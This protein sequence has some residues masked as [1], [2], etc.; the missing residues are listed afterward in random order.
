MRPGVLVVVL[1]VVLLVVGL[2]EERE[3]WHLE[4]WHLHLWHLRGLW[5]LDLKWVVVLVGVVVVGVVV[6]RNQ[7][8][9][10][11]LLSSFQIL[12]ELLN[13]SL[14]TLEEFVHIWEHELKWINVLVLVVHVEFLDLGVEGLLL[15]VGSLNGLVPLVVKATEGGGELT[16]IIGESVKL[17][18]LLDVRVAGVINV[19]ELADV[20][21][22]AHDLEDVI[23]DSA[24]HVLHEDALSWVGDAPV[25][26]VVL[27][28]LEVADLG[29]L[30]ED[31]DQLRSDFLDLVDVDRPEVLMGF[32]VELLGLVDWSLNPGTEALIGDNFVVLVV[33]TGDEA[34]VSVLHE[35][36][37]HLNF[38][39][40]WSTSLWAVG[41]HLVVIVLDWACLNGTDSGEEK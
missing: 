11:L 28:S 27:D 37:V 19:H 18:H 36:S 29:V 35:E 20:E 23:E 1:R 26:D 9:G 8:M 40:L 25:L 39:Q 6:A 31:I 16:E 32:V 12:E 33:E 17:S 24:L 2:W 22:L 34:L 10:E 38:V 5:S 13:L 30:E 21:K 3:L 7:G 41:F 14:E 15:D 4:L